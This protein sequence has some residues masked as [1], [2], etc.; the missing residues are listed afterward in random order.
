MPRRK[1]GS[2]GRRWPAGA[3]TSTYTGAPGFTSSSSA[4]SNEVS[5][6]TASTASGSRA[7]AGTSTSGTVPGKA[8]AASGRCS[9][10][11]MMGS[12]ISVEARPGS[13]CYGCARAGRLSL[14]SVRLGAEMGEQA[15]PG[16]G[17]HPDGAPEVGATDAGLARHLRK[18]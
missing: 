5:A 13:P 4:T 16:A 6:G 7:L 11:V 8:S 9:A 10:S 12:S 1:S 2:T 17:R 3:V 18:R 14:L 15:L